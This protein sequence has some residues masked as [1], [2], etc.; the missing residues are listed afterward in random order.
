MKTVYVMLSSYNGEKY[1]AEQIDSILRQT[2]VSVTLAIRDDG[3]SDGTGEIL[4]RY[5]SENEN[6]KVAF[7]ENVGYAKSFFE[8]IKT[9]PEGFDY[10]ALSDQDDV[11][12]EDKLKSAVDMLSEKEGPRLYGCNPELVDRELSHIGYMRPPTKDDFKKGRYLIDK[13]SYGC[14]MVFDPALRALAVS[15]IPETKVSHDNWLGLLAVFCG[16]FVFDE[17]SFIKYRQHG[18]NVTGGKSGLLQTWKRRMKNMKNLSDLSRRDIAE[19][20]LNAFSSDFDEETKDLLTMV[21]DYKKSFK[22]R[23][24]FFFDKRTKRKSAEKNFV[25]RMMILFGKA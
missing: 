3:S 22:R 14:T 24:R 8:L 7:G 5:A 16:E 18:N 9:S 21:R 25:F 6:V 20:L 17:R 23:M 12:A 15:H 1:I 2:G 19:E 13:Y 10:Y 4:R 11:W